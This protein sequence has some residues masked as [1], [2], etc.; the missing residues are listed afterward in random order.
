MDVA[1]RRSGVDAEALLDPPVAV[2]DTL[3]TTRTV[4]AL[5]VDQFDAPA[6]VC[7][8]DRGSS[9]SRLVATQASTSC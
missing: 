3:G 8:R 2:V 6:P 5:V 9:P 1:Y 7:A 4:G